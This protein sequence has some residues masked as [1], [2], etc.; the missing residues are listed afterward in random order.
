MTLWRIDESTDKFISVTGP[1]VKP[2]VGDYV[3]NR[4]E[5][6]RLHH[7]RHGRM[8]IVPVA[9]DVIPGVLAQFAA[10]RG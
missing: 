5:L 1:A 2:A 10:Q 8:P 7:G 3:I 6:C 9:Q 4:G